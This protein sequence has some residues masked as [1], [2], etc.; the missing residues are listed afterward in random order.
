MKTAAT[1]VISALTSVSFDQWV[2]LQDPCGQG[3]CTF[4]LRGVKLITPAALVQLAAAC[5]ALTRDGRRPLI[6]FGDSTVVSYLERAGFITAVRS[7]ARFSSPVAASGSKF[8]RGKSQV[9]IEVTR[10]QAGTELPAIL[11]K[12][13][14]V[15]STQ[16]KYQK[17]DA[18]DV[19]IAISEVAQNTFDHN[20]GHTCGFLAMQ[21]Y[22]LSREEG[23]FLEIGIA[24]YG[25]GL[26]TTLRRNPKSA[27][28]VSD[29]DAIIRATKLG[30]SEYDEP[31]RGTGLYHLLEKAYAHDGT[32]QIR[33]G[34]AKVRFRM[35]K[36]QGWGFQVYP[37]PGVQIALVLRAKGRA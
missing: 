10:I 8:R 16:L 33:T 2:Q 21:V 30:T 3:A 6:T 29:L 22:R 36:K 7:A 9:L 27:P 37:L 23:R 26:A 1:N 17:R 31:T 12:V 4:D 35:D 15:L 19:A 11:E 24:D 5:H 14:E 18:F 20:H 13:I 28:L 25:E 34:A 32:V